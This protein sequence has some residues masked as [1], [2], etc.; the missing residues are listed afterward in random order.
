M[1]EVVRVTSCRWNRDHGHTLGALESL[2]DQG[3]RKGRDP[4]HVTPWTKTK[5]V[6]KGIP[7]PIALGHHIPSIERLNTLRH[8]P[9]VNRP[10]RRE[11][12][13]DDPTICA[14]KISRR[15]HYK[16]YWLRGQYERIRH[17]LNHCMMEH[18]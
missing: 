16:T 3:S 14:T 6:V 5:G 12:K 1:S 10:F 18:K 17:R 11:N 7:R 15:D 2:R 8:L 9:F 13:G 4:H